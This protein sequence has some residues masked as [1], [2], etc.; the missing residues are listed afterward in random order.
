MSLLESLT[1]SIESSTDNVKEQSG[2]V[3]DS[4][5]DPGTNRVIGAMQQTDKMNNF[6]SAD[7]LL[8]GLAPTNDLRQAASSAA[9]RPYHG[10]NWHDHNP[11]AVQVEQINYQVTEAPQR[12][13]TEV[14]E[15]VVTVI[16]KTDSEKTD[17]EDDHG[18]G[19][20]GGLND[21]TD[22]ISNM[23][24]EVG[25]LVSCSGVSG[26]LSEVGGIFGG[27]GG[28]STSGDGGGSSGG[29]LGG[30]FGDVVKALPAVAS[31]ASLLL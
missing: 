12:F 31:V 22:G 21:L 18:G 10:A 25:Q 14:P 19:I 29:G 7:S 30:I 13:Y 4:L 1:N 27:S 5:L 9:E 15:S 8:G 23:V 6:P 17:S 2:L 28:N 3:G 26:L 20:L 11:G 24:G 16:D